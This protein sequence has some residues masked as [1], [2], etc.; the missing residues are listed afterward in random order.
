MKHRYLATLVVATIT[1]LAPACSRD[2]DNLAPT[3]PA[4]WDA[5]ATPPVT[6][7]NRDP[8]SEGGRRYA[9][10]V[11]DPEAYFSTLSR[12]V[13]STL[14]A[15]PSDTINPVSAL[16]IIVRDYDGAAGKSGYGTVVQIDISSRWL[17]KL[18]GT[19]DD[20]RRELEGVLVHELTHAYQL[21]PRGIPGY[22]QG[23]EFWAYIEGCADAVRLL[24]GYLDADDYLPDLERKKYLAGYSITGFFLAWLV[25]HK[26]PDFLR[27]FNQSTLHVTPWSFQGGVRHVLGPQSDI[28]Q[29]W[30]EYQNSRK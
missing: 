21:E 3:Y 18:T 1:L 19:T 6:S 27:R 13:L 24:A 12:L 26:D 14:Y 25:Q 29:L 30:I 15:S 9:T 2:D 16:N 8:T 4:A 22:S 28:D 20:I 11:P 17:G 7:D 5:Y 23:N 10:L